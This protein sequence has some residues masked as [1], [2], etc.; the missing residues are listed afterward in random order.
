MGLPPF[1]KH[2]QTSREAA[3]A[4]IN[5]APT[6]KSKVFLAIK[7][8]GLTGMTDEEQQIMLKMNPSTQRPRRI[9]LVSEGKVKD[10]GR[11][12]HTKAK[13]KAVVWVLAKQ[14]VRK[15]SEDHV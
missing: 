8:S 9:D 14:P 7:H 10:S 15:K 5:Q 12:R 3:I 6:Q 13:R 1:Q 4:A 2:S 11:V